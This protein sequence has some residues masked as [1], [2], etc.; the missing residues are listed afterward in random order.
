MTKIHTPF[1]YDYVGSFLR[2]EALKAARADFEAGKISEEELHKT[3]DQCITDLVNKQKKAGYHVIT[4]GEFR[5]STWHLDFMWGF[6]GVEHHKT[7]KGIAFHGE[8]ALI[9]DTY[10][11]GKIS[12]GHHPFVDHFKF[13]KALEDENTVAKQTIPAPA[14]FFLQMIVPENLESTR[15]FY[16]TDEE[17]IA[18]IAKAYQKVIRDFYDAGCRNLQF[19]DC[20]WGLC[21]SDEENGNKEVNDYIKGTM[22]QLLTVNNLALENR[23]EDLVVTTHVCRGNYHST[24]FSS[25]AYDPVA[26]TLFVCENVD[27]YY[28]EYDDERS[29]GFEPLKYAH[30]K[31]DATAQ[32]DDAVIRRVMEIADR[33]EVSMTEVALAWLIS[34]V[35]SPVVGATKLHHIEGAAKAVDLVLSPEETAY[36]EEPYVPHRLVGVMAQNTKAAAKEDHVWSTGD[37]KIK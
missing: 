29:G 4:D 35:T 26:E 11:V 28:L 14:Q 8:P 32:Q 21:M 36:L 17:L 18:D 2:P 13:V 25:G 27:A 23:P 24:F 5:R 37:Q 30:F 20:S 1:R 31:Y 33:H 12:A 34:K 15:K 3:E 16:P 19:D 6:N 9:D 7:E 22:E 10:L